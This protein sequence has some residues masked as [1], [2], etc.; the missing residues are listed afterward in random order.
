MSEASERKYLAEISR[1]LGRP[2][3]GMIDNSMNGAENTDKLRTSWCNVKGEHIGRLDD[4]FYDADSLVETMYIK[5]PGESDGR[6]GESKAPA[7]EFD[8][9]LLIKQVS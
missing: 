9:Q 7:G 8:E 4:T 1:R 6:C 2:L 3:Y 5:A